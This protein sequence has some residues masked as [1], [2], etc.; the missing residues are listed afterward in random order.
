MEFGKRTLALHEAVG[1]GSYSTVYRCVIDDKEYAAKVIDQNLVLETL[2]ELVIMCSIKHDSLLSAVFHPRII[3]HQMYIITPLAVSDLWVYTRANGS[4]L[5]RAYHSSWTSQLCQ[6][7]YILHHYDIIHGDIK[8]KNVLVM[9]DN[10][11]VLGDFTSSLLLQ[12]QRRRFTFYS[13]TITH[14]SLEEFMAR[15]TPSRY[16][17][18]GKPQDIWALGNTLVEMSFDGRTIVKF[19]GKAD[20]DGGDLDTV[21]KT[22]KQLTL[23]LR[24]DVDAS[25]SGMYMDAQTYCLDCTQDLE[26]TSFDYKNNTVFKGLVDSVF[27]LDPAKRPSAHALTQHPYI[28]AHPFVKGSL[29]QVRSQA[30][31]NEDRFWD[32]INI[33]DTIEKEFVLSIFRKI[34]QTVRYSEH[35]TK[36]IAVLAAALLTRTNIHD[37]KSS[38]RKQLLNALDKIGMRLL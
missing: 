36:R 20:N 25:T 7:V 8:A 17:W 34:Y 29:I 15:I 11:L 27:A 23:F 12:G 19:C 1:K 2:L 13:T 24:N 18:T 9:S 32:D 30:V 3:K 38:D 28:S 5:D 6:A 37:L 35:Q 16:Y 33:P 22:V 10:R 4:A 14:R 31:V 21:T 26:P